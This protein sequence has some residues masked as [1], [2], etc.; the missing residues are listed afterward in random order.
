MLEDKEKVTEIPTAE[1]LKEKKK[2]LEDLFRILNYFIKILDYNEL[3][4]NRFLNTRKK[5]KYYRLL[6][7]KI[8]F[9]LISYFVIIGYGLFNSTIP[10]N[11]LI[12]SSYLFGLFLYFF[13]YIWNHLDNLSFKKFGFTHSYFHK[14][15]KQMKD[16]QNQI[17]LLFKNKFLLDFITK[18]AYNELYKNLLQDIDDKVGFYSNI[19]E[20]F[21][22]QLKKYGF[23]GTFISLIIGFILNLIVQYFLIESAIEIFVNQIIIIPSFYVLVLILAYFQFRYQ[24]NK[25]INKQKKLLVVSKKRLSFLV[26]HVISEIYKKEFKDSEIQTREEIDNLKKE[27]NEKIKEKK[28]R[29]GELKTKFNKIKKD[30]KE[31]KT[32]IKGSELDKMQ[33]NLKPLENELNVIKK[34]FKNLKK[35]LKETKKL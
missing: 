33:E 18:K 27:L 3:D 26:Y 10:A 34:E 24:K 35:G 29:I 5:Q 31:N 2:F 28:E 11:Y 22:Y 9:S 6:S 8:A 32:G 15:K 23:I 1:E 13:V 30:I 7:I 16:F 20:P 4:I 17:K 21:F 25:R 14:E 12:L 19:I